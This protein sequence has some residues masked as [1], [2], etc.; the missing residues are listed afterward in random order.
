M[1]TA[2]FTLALLASQLC[3]AQQRFFEA[4]NN[5]WG[6]QNLSVETKNS[7]VISGF[8]E[9]NPMTG[10]LCPAF[11]INN[12]GGGPVSSFRL[13]YP[14]NV[15][16]MDFTLRQPTNTLVFVAT[17]TNPGGV[18]PYKMI[19]GEWDYTTNT[20]VQSIYHQNAQS[21][22]PH[23]VIV[24]ET[25]G[26]VVMAGTRV[27]G[28]MNAANFN[29]IPKSGFVLGVNLANFAAVVI[30]RE[31]NT[32]M[33]GTTDNDMLETLT[34]V[35]GTGYFIAGSGNGPA[36]EQNIYTMGVTYGNAVM[37]GLL[38]DNT[39]FRAAAAH[40]VFRSGN[41]FLLANSSVIHQF[42]LAR[43][44]PATGAY[45]TPLTSL[46]I[47]TLPIGGGVDQNG[48]R[49]QFNNAGQIVIGGYLSAPTGLMPQLL[50]PFHM[51]VT[52]A[53]AFVDGHYQQSGNNAPLTG[54]FEERGNSV[55]IN[56]PD[57][58]AFNSTANR[59][60]TVS[61][62]SVLGGFDLN[63]MSTAAANCDRKF[64]VTP[65]N[66]TPIVVSAG[67]FP[68]ISTIPTPYDPSPAPR[69]I[70]QSQLCPAPSPAAMGQVSV[71]PN[72]ANAE[73]NIDLGDEAQVTSVTVF[74][75]KGNKVLETAVTERLRGVF[76]LD[77]SRLNAGVY[78]ITVRD[79][80]GVEYREK[81]VKE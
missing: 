5:S 44:N 73:L 46:Q 79:A 14:D 43:C 27:N 10:L 21:M 52:P 48:F 53:F 8:T 17:V 19:I 74:D 29:T 41:V 75:M 26:Q 54:Y 68:P 56:T 1:K 7:F 3:V 34:E 78:L 22:I 80:D 23:Q 32:P 4:T 11:K 59:S 2:L 64:S 37:F 61:Q 33:T 38:A 49:I 67:S 51:T 57:M 13:P 62:N 76:A 58:L 35:P 47:N 50:T 39:N 9:V 25:A 42:A 81:F 30:N 28:I 55:Y 72:P 60:Y 12:P 71:Y 69:P 6:Y 65:F 24:S 66:N 18:A 45:L 15:C 70:A 20:M 16:L 77:I 40:V 63:I 31:M 36:N